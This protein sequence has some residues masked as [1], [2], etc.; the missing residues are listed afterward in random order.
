MFVCVFMDDGV[1]LLL[2]SASFVVVFKSEL[3]CYSE[4]LQL[5]RGPCRLL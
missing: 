5:I 1:A 2:S 4:G 3:V